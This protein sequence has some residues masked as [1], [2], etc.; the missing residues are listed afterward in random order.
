MDVTCNRGLHVTSLTRRVAC[1][2]ICDVT[3]ENMT[4]DVTRDD[5][6]SGHMHVI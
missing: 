4:C 1:D 2:I 6:L 5:S 3:D